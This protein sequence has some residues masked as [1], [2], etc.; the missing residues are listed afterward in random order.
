MMKD[1]GK[2]DFMYAET[3]HVEADNADSEIMEAMKHCEEQYQCL[4]DAS[5]DEEE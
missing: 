5:V 4:L 3:V 2:L 1:R